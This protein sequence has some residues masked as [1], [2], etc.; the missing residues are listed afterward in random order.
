MSSRQMRRLQHLVASSTGADGDVEGE[1]GSDALPSTMRQT[2]GKPKKA[3]KAQ[4]AEGGSLHAP[5]ASAD[6]NNKDNNKDNNNDNNNDSKGSGVF[7]A[8][9]RGTGKGGVLSTDEKTARK[10]TEERKKRKKKKPNDNGNDEQS[11]GGVSSPSSPTPSSKAFLVESRKESR[12]AQ[13]GRHQRRREDDEDDAVL[14]AALDRRVREEGFHAVYGPRSEGGGGGRGGLSDPDNHGLLL[15]LMTVADATRLDTRVERIRSFGVEAVE[16]VGDGSV[17]RHRADG[18]PSDTGSNSFFPE[19]HQR[20]RFRSCAFATPNRYRWPP[21]DSLGMALKV[22]PRPAAALPYR[23]D[24]NEPE[25]INYELDTDTPAFHRAD[26]AR[27]R[28]AEMHD[29]VQSLVNCL[30]EYGCYHIP[31]LLQVSWSF[32]ITDHAAHAQELMDLALY[33]VGM[34]LSHI[35]IEATWQQRQLPSCLPS[36]AILHA[37][38]SRSVHIAL[39]RGCARTAWETARF[40]LSLDPTDPDGMLLQLD[41]LALRSKRWVWLLK[42]FLLARRHLLRQ[43]P[44]W[45]LPAKLSAAAAGNVPTLTQDDLVGT[46]ALDICRLPGFAFSAAL[47]KYSLERERLRESEAVGEG[48]Q[49]QRYRSKVL[50]DMT[51]EETAFLSEPSVPTAQQMLADAIALFP[52]AAGCL[53]EALRGVQTVCR[54]AA[55][56]VDSLWTDVLSKG[57][58]TTRPDDARSES[59]D[60]LASLFASRHSDMW[61]SQ[62]ALRFLQSVLTDASAGSAEERQSELRLAM[63]RTLPLRSRW[64]SY[65]QHCGGSDASALSRDLV[66]IR[67]YRGVSGEDVVGSVGTTIPA[68]LLAPFQEDFLD[69]DAEEWGQEESEEVDLSGTSRSASMLSESFDG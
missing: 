63:A 5:E 9:D 55:H 27:Q 1:D 13:R 34:L 41:Y 43:P 26:E 16:D 44:D 48:G 39:R 10:D 2:K 17:P 33:Q 36:N 40:L 20:L 47:A 29:P 37:V 3:K 61:K 35:R 28:C 46:L 45:P 19:H 59:T 69:A 15:E 38:L 11:G 14:Q 54:G 65:M 58:A 66:S 51:E 68:E 23:C 12:W 60:H 24:P 22:V 52:E 4:H 31:T 67:S 30:G 8:E 62:E 25:E 7:Q 56:P 53:L 21:Y 57:A 6:D 18:R 42:V 50:R 49:Q 32:E 64:A